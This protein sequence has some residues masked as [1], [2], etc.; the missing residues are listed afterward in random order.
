MLVREVILEEAA[1]LVR[2]RPSWHRPRCGEC[3]APGPGYDRSPTRRWRSLNLG[4]VRVQLEYEPQRVSCDD[5]KRVVTERVPWAAHGSSFTYDFEELTAY[6][7]Q[8][9]DK[10]SVTEVMGINWR[11]VGNIVER[12]IDRHRDGDAFGAP[13]RIGVDEFSYRR[14]HNYLT[15]V[16]DH[17]RRRVIWVGEGRSAESLAKFFDRLGEER[18]AAIEQATIDF[19]GGYQKAIRERLPRAEVIFDRFHV[20]RLASD[21]LDEVR[22]TL[23]RE[24]SNA[25]DGAA[26]KGTRWA[27]LRNPWDLTNRDKARLRDVERMY[28]PLYRAYLLKES[29]AQALDYRQ[30]K[31][32]SD[33]L[34]R[35]LSWAHR[36]RL[37]PFVRVARTIRQHR[38]GILAYIRMRLTNGLVEGL[39]NRLRMI[40]R[41]AYGFHSWRPLAAMLFLCCGGITL[42]PPLP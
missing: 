2:V 13:V 24:L 8:I 9:T 18:C 6:L 16:V 27:L 31:R 38:D 22:R 29:L 11:T 7:A 19:S 25:E 21:A 23:V 41:R 1:L 33:A 28:K 15:V 10:T 34:D 42:S 40:A 14:F 3:G 5:C 30:P 17:D 39:N 37:K 36:S 4:A 35:W 20:Q 32:A 26:V 12:V